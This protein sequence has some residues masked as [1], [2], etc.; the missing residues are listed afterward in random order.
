MSPIHSGFGGAATLSLLVISFGISSNGAQI[1]MDLQLQEVLDVGLVLEFI[2]SLESGK[3]C[4]RS[5]DSG[6]NDGT[7]WQN[8]KKLPGESSL[9]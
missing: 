6:A 1:S 2:P 7:K 9:F 4:N 3:E 8:L 5:S